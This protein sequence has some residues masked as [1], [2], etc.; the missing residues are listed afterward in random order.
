M[1]DNLDYMVATLKLKSIGTKID[2]L[3]PAQKKY[4]SSWEVGT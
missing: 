1:P 4:L 2:Y 3:T